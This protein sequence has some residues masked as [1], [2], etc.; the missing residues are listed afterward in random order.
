M[1][2]QTPKIDWAAPDMPLDI[3]LNRIEGNTL[4]LYGTEGIVANAP[5]Y[6][7][8]FTTQQYVNIY[9][10]VRGATVALPAIAEISMKELSATSNAT[11][12]ASDTTSIPAACRPATHVQVPIVVID[13]GYPLL[14]TIWIY[15][16]G[17]FAFNIATSTIFT[18]SGTKGFKAFTA[19]YPI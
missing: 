9:W 18:A 8:A 4:D 13:N 1:A 7:G 12:F 15:T 17:D 19:R 14:G 2:W 6:A 16:T 5:I 11:S 3:D 10:R